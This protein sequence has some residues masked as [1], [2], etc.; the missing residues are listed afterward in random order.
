MRDGRVPEEANGGGEKKQRSDS[1]GESTSV[2]LVE[3]CE[4]DGEVVSFG[5]CSVE[6]ILLLMSRLQGAAVG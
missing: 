6:F 2:G 4:G 1:R 3:D 5:F